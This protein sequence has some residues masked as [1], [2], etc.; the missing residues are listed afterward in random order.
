MP[1]NNLGSV[2][3]RKSDGRWIA[4]FWLGD[5]KIVKYAASERDAKHLLS[6][7]QREHHV[8][9]L[10]APTKV[11]LETWATDWLA[12]VAPTLR[13]SSQQTYRY[14]LDR[15]LPSL[16]KARLDKLT[17]PVIAHA[18]ARLA[19]VHG[20]TRALEQSYTYL[21]AC[22]ERAVLL[23]MVGHNPMDRVPR[24][25]A[26]KPDGTYWTVEQA[27]SFL[28]T[29]TGADLQYAPLLVFLLGTGMRVSEA[30]GL[31]WADLDLTTGTAQVHRALVWVGQQPAIQ[32]PK[33]SK[34]HRTIALPDFVLSTLANLPRPLT[35]DLPIFTT[36]T[37]STPEP[38]NVRRTL[39][40]LCERATVPTIPVHGLRHVHA[41]LLIRSGI[42]IKTAQARLGHATAAM[43]LNVY[44]TALGADSSAADAVNRIVVPTTTISTK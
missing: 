27:Q 14:A 43:T 34:G 32:Q 31:R 24:P 41:S 39:R 15:V 19:A 20:A 26:P 22:L 35:P 44:A 9:T 25:K 33:S 23:G 18:F 21:H 6:T 8:G 30:L 12:Q 17:A 36:G 16:G 42:D 38:A 2:Y 1:R 28:A 13:P 29:A 3:Q 11:T 40:T 5:K 10:A 7:L 37:G 4:A